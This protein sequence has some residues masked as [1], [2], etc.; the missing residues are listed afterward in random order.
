MDELF[1]HHSPAQYAQTPKYMILD[2]KNI[3]HAATRLYGYMC[4]RGGPAH[5]IDKKRDTMADAFETSPATI[6]SWIQQLAAKDWVVVEETITNAG[7]K[8]NKYHT[9]GD[10]DDAMQWRVLNEAE[11]RLTPKPEVKP[12]QSRKGVG[13]RTTHKPKETQVDSGSQDQL[14][15]TGAV[16]LS[17]PPIRNVDPSPELDPSL[18]S[19]DLSLTPATP[20]ETKVI[21]VSTVTGRLESDPKILYMGRKFGKLAASDWQ[22]LYKIDKL[23]KPADGT[24]LEVVAKNLKSMLLNDVLFARLDELRGRILACYCDPEL[25]H[26]HTHK[27]LAETDEVGRQKWRR[28]AREIDDPLKLLEAFME[29]VRDA[30]IKAA[31]LKALG[32]HQQAQVNAAREAVKAAAPV[33]AK[34]ETPPTEIPVAPART[35]TQQATHDLAERLL[36]PKPERLRVWSV[37]PQGIRWHYLKDGDTTACNENRFDP[38]FFEQPQPDWDL[39]QAKE[40]GHCGIVSKMTSTLRVESPVEASPEPAPTEIPATDAPT[41]IFWHGP[42][43]TIIHTIQPGT[44][45]TWCGQSITG[46]HLSYDIGPAK[47][48]HPAS[49]CTGCARGK[50]EFAHKD[51][52]VPAGW[53]VA[54]KQTPR[55]ECLA[56]TGFYVVDHGPKYLFGK[57]F[58]RRS[59]A[60]ESII[61]KTTPNRGVESVDVITSAYGPYTLLVEDKPAASTA[62]RDHEK[63]VLDAYYNGLPKI[64]QP[65]YRRYPQEKRKYARQWL[66][67]HHT[68]EQM[69]AVVAMEY[70]DP[71]N[72][73][74][75]DRIG[76]QTLG[77]G[78][79]LDRE[80]ILIANLSKAPAPQVVEDEDP[81]KPTPP[82][83]TNKYLQDDYFRRLEEESANGV[84]YRRRQVLPPKRRVEPRYLQWWLALLGDLK[85]KLNQQT[86]NSWLGCLDIVEGHDEE[87]WIVAPNSYVSDYVLKHF[88]GSMTDIITPMIL[89]PNP[90]DRKIKLHVE[91]WDVDKIDD[92]AESEPSTN[93]LTT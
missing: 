76:K 37:E 64:L 26:C 73:Y 56:K 69:Q 5:E 22:N 78:T 36:A 29:E 6:T 30:S 48:N 63:E 54:E 57:R 71:E 38:K 43:H 68:A 35:I 14:K 34:V 50:S 25:C 16:N 66:H 39:E 79:I 9:F 86:Y 45:H 18:Q 21:H 84:E 87:I 82:V 3:S 55:W 46:D 59:D 85:I 61:F 2:I 27:V 32:D 31:Y 44:Q 74:W 52:P 24:R 33:E 62:P 17:L 80:K 41:L 65:T 13:G 90:D 75:R 11:L 23:D 49:S 70:N 8:A 81:T 67:L 10:Q 58:D 19:N 92:Q 53:K 89:Y 42:K 60:I 12:I 4:I 20:G 88:L 15:L 51:D 40:C 1:V 72:S 91:V 93:H 83:A 28:A 47:T 7:R 77:L